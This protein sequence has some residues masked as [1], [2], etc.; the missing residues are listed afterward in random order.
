MKDTNDVQ[1]DLLTLVAERASETSDSFVRVTHE[2]LG[3]LDKDATMSEVVA[4]MVAGNLIYVPSQRSLG[5]EEGY[6]FALT[7]LGTELLASV[8]AKK[9]DKVAAPVVAD[10]TVTKAPVEK[11][12][13]KEDKKEVAKTDEKKVEEKKEDKKED[14]KTDDK[15]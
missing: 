10:V 2:E 11:E 4:E 1:K 3:K 9:S 8:P 6:E 7:T 13:K 5:D 14:E 12:E 15:K